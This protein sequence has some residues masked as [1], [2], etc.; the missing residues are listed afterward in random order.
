MGQQCIHIYKCTLTVELLYTA[1][2]F[3]ISVYYRLYITSNGQEVHNNI[4]VNVHLY[5]FY[6]AV[7]FAAMYNNISV[8]IS[9]YII[10][11][12]VEWDSSA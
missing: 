8:Y 4:T 7:P 6:T 3:D 10:I 1:V 9:S 5:I 2:P 12:Y 11:H